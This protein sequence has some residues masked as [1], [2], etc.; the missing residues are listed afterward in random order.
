MKGEE[1]FAIFALKLYLEYSKGDNLVVMQKGVPSYND[2]PF[3]II[4]V[5]CYDLVVNILCPEQSA[6]VAE[7][8]LVVLADSSLDIVLVVVQLITWI[9]QT[10]R[11]CWIASQLIILA[12]LTSG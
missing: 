11:R 7:R 1:C 4:L 6:E 2:T 12:K 3:I 9:R 8:L 5:F 10:I